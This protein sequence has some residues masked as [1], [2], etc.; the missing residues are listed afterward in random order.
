M[1]QRRKSNVENQAS[2]LHH[3]SLGKDQQSRFLE[4][5]FHGIQIYV[6]LMPCLLTVSTCILFVVWIVCRLDS[7]SRQ[8][9]RGLGIAG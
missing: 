6:E 7:S 5:V 3:L 8:I 1:Q 2:I 4:D 9:P